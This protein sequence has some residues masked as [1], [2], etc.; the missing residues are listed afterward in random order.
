MERSKTIFGNDI[1]VRDYRK[2]VRQKEKSPRQRS[3]I[4][5]YR[6]EVTKRYSGIRLTGNHSAKSVMTA[7]LVGASDCY[8]SASLSSS[9]V[10]PKV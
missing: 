9:S 1:A 5:S 7:K 2:A 8:R 3:W 4:T 10:Y 6:T